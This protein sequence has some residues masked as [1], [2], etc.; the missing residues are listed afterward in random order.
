MSYYDGPDAIRVADVRLPK[1]KAEGDAALALID[2]R[3]SSI[4]S[5]M[6]Q[7]GLAGRSTALLERTWARWNE[8]RGDVVYAMTLIAEG[9]D[10]PCLDCS[11]LRTIIV[12]MEADA[13]RR[14]HQIAALQRDET[15]A[16]DSFR[17]Q[18][19]D[20]VEKN[21]R[22]SASLREMREQGSHKK[23][24]TD[25]PATVDSQV[26]REKRRADGARS[27][28]HDAVA[29]GISAITSMVNAG[30]QMTED[31]E[32]YIRRYTPCLPANYLAAWKAKHDALVSFDKATGAD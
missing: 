11:N 4:E 7:A 15:P 26:A 29:A 23:A 9:V 18:V 21:A 27:A 30:A 31:A 2:G 17:R 16:L 19:A 10:A 25:E 28:Q 5:S 24:A 1:T 3:L 22:L 8:R 13:K 12:N 32:A 20:L 14:S 6:E